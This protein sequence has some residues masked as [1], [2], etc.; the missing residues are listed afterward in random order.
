[1]LSTPC[2]HDCETAQKELSRDFSLT[3]IENSLVGVLG[4]GAEL[5]GGCFSYLAE[6]GMSRDKHGK[7][8]VDAGPASKC[9]GRR[10]LRR[11]EAL[12]GWDRGICWRLSDLAGELISVDGV[13]AQREEGLN[14]RVRSR[15]SQRDQIER[16]LGHRTAAAGAVHCAGRPR[17]QMQ[18]TSAF[19]T[20]R[21]RVST[22]TI[23]L[24][25]EAS[26][27]Q[28]PMTYSKS[29]SGVAQLRPGRRYHRGG[30]REPAPPGTDAHGG[31]A[32]QIAIATG[33][34]SRQGLRGQGQQH[35]LGGVDHQGAAQL[36]RPRTGRGDRPQPRRPL[37][38]PVPKAPGS[39]PRERGRGAGGG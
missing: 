20:Q 16:R 24:E 31:G 39:Q 21:L 28:Q 8:Q 29:R 30:I 10:L 4:R 35:Q 6:I 15:T 33:Q 11:H 27:E 25:T 34:A 38:L 32:R 1:M 17:G 26:A 22:A 13:I 36:A 37:R 18:S 19:L 9:D 2:G 23:S 3:S 5:P 7:M 12:R 14:S